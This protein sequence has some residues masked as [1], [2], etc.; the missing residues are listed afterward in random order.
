[1]FQATIFNW[2]YVGILYNFG[3]YFDSLG[4]P[5]HRRSEN[6]NS[7]FFSYTQFFL[8]RVNMKV[9]IFVVNLK[10]CLLHNILCHVSEIMF[11]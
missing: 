6:R 10:C 7:D 9:R 11:Y 3:L 4:L 1:M 5:F 8:Q 2:K